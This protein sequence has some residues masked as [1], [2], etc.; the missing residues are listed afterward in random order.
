[1]ADTLFKSEV[2]KKRG[3]FDTSFGAIEINVL[4]SSLEPV[5]GAQV[6]ID[7]MLKG[8][9][10]ADSRSIGSFRICFSI[11][12]YTLRVE[13]NGFFN[14]MTITVKPLVSD[15]IDIVLEHGFYKANHV[16]HW[17]AFEIVEGLTYSEN[18]LTENRGGAHLFIGCTTTDNYIIFDESQV[19]VSFDMNLRP[20]P[21][22]P[23]ITAPYEI[24]VNG[25][26]IHGNVLWNQV[27]DLSGTLHWSKWI[28]VHVSTPNIKYLQFKKTGHILY[29]SI[30]NIRVVK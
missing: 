6:F 8:V 19:V 26:D 20:V 13:K 28:T 15:S 12:A 5:A 3:Y 30:N 24:E 27:V 1:M 16:Y 29:P 7:G 23:C 22:D 17:G 10:G 4:D 25:L 14:E 21:N 18:M 11:G 9:T 2:E